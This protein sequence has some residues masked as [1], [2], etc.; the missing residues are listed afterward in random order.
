MRLILVRHGE[1]DGN[2]RGILQGQFD[3]QLTEKGRAQ[4]RALGARLRD[5]P[6]D[7]AFSS[8]LSRAVDTAAAVLAGRQCMV[9]YTPLLRERHF[10]AMEGKPLGEWRDAV[11]KSGLSTF[12]ICPEGGESF[13]DLMERAYAFRERMSSVFEDQTVLAVGHGAVNRAVLLAFLGYPREEWLKLIQDNTCVN[14]LERENDGERYR[15]LVLNCTKH[16]GESLAPHRPVIRST[17][18]PNG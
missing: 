9:E 8:D 5:E 3:G 15:A 10:G 18:N 16:L 17:C 13:A 11:A 12:D 2:I 7:L 14:V 6:I 4:A 1:T